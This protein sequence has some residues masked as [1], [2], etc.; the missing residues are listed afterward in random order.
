MKKLVPF[1]TTEEV[2]IAVNDVIEGGSNATG[3]VTLTL[4]VASTV[5]S[6]KL[7]R[8][9]SVVGLTPRT[10]VAATELGNGTIYVSTVTNGS[11]TLVHASSA[12]AGRTFDFTLIGG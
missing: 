2:S 12:V 5:V 6:H 7:C 3:S 9:T 10:A 11:F 8:S 4:S 1:P